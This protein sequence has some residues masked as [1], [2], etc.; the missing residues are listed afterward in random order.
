[1][2]FNISIIQVE[3]TTKPGKTA[4]YQQLEIAY[5]NLN[6]GKVGSKKMASFDQ[7]E[8]N[9][10]KALADAKNGDTFNIE[11]N[12]V[13]DYW[14]WEKATQAAPGSVSA[15]AS[16]GLSTNTPKSSYE[17]TEERAHRQVLIVKQSSLSAASTVLTAGA[18]APPEAN[19]VLEL[20]QVFANWV[21][22]K[23]TVPQP[24]LDDMSNDIPY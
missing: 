20:A 13:G 21:F 18:K 6:D 4:S 10:F 8:Q 22:A 3:K 7:V 23:P 11:S 14:K 24:T 12:K 1:M 19:A 16:Q 5:K 15:P 2:N 17:T 9:S